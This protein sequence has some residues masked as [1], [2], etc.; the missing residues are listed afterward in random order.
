[1]CIKGGG[2]V[3]IPPCFWEQAPL[4]SAA[5]PSSSCLLVIEFGFVGGLYGLCRQVAP[6]KEKTAPADKLPTYKVWLMGRCG[7]APPSLTQEGSWLCF[8]TCH[9]L[10][11]CEQRWL[12]VP[13][14]GTVPVALL[15]AAVMARGF[16][17]SRTNHQPGRVGGREAALRDCIQTH[18]PGKQMLP[19][20][21]LRAGGR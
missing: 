14:W 16:W 10:A 7:L 6:P 8:C 5:L 20:R 3:W 21:M 9:S 4:A 19:P 11:D 13:I 1:M 12:E 17:P 15:E 18:S 2:R